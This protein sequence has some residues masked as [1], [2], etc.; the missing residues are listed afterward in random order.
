MK[1]NFSLNHYVGN[2]VSCIANQILDSGFEIYII[3]LVLELVS[4]CSPCEIKLLQIEVVNPEEEVGMIRLPNVEGIRNST[5]KEEPLN[6]TF[7]VEEIRKKEME[8]YM[9]YDIGSY[10]KDDWNLAQKLMVNGSDALP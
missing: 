10:C 5:M 9:D 2:I 6:N 8:E 3:V 7:A 4:L 1:G